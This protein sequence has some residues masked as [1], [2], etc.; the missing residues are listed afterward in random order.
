MSAVFSHKQ[1]I[2]CPQS[3]RPGR[4]LD[5]TTLLTSAGSYNVALE[6]AVKRHMPKL[7]DRINMLKV[8][9]GFCVSFGNL[10][11]HSTSLSPRL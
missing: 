1:L 8:C 6:L 10:R 4:A 2:L 9:V 5:Y 11:F 3:N 7:A